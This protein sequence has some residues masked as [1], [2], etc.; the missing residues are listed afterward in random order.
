MGRAGGPADP[1]ASPSPQLSPTSQDLG[2]SIEGQVLLP[3]WPRDK[4]GGPKDDDF[5]NRHPIGRG[6]RAPTSQEEAPD[7]GPGHAPGPPGD[8]HGARGSTRSLRVSTG[9]VTTWPMLLL[10]VFWLAV[11]ALC[12]AGQVAVGVLYLLTVEPDYFPGDPPAADLLLE[13]ALVLWLFIITG[14]CGAF[15]WSRFGEQNRVVRAGGKTVAVL[16][17][18]SVLSLSPV[19][20]HVGRRHFGEWRQLKSMIRQGEA[21]VLELVQRE[22]GMLSREEVQLAR[23]WFLEHPVYFKFEDLPQPVQVRVMSSLP[24]YVGVDFGGGNN[25]LFDPDTM[26]CT[27]SD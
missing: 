15:A 20:A 27:F 25:A 6:T 14:L 8:T 1:A 11:S 17:A 23:A 2:E 4:L 13:G 26:I 16:L 5:L 3:D 18:L 19:L 24:P 9:S 12:G 22:G 10:L 7:A 21:K